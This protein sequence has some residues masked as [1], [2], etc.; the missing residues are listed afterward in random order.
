MGRF[1]ALE[2]A[3]NYRFKKLISSP[4]ALTHKSIRSHIIMRDWRSWEAAK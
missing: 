2:D 1:K 3:L 4:K